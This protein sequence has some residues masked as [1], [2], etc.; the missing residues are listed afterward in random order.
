[1]STDH[2]NIERFIAVYASNLRAIHGGDAAW[3][4]RLPA[5][6]RKETPEKTFEAFAKQTTTNLVRGTGSKNTDA[7]KRT[8]LHFGIKHTYKA[9][10]EYV[11]ATAGVERTDIYA[12]TYCNQGHRVIDGQPVGHHCYVLPPA[13]LICER[14]GNI[15]KAL[16]ILKMFTPLREASFRRTRT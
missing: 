15:E 3:L 11:N 12:T 6:V 13:A 9:I 16:A 5:D 7:L 10:T 4:A 2:T 1:M 8:C 14:E